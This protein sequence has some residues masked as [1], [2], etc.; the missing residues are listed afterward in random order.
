MALITTPT[1][2][3]YLFTALRLHINDNTEPYTF[4]DD[5]LRT[6]LVYAVKALQPRWNYKYLVDADNNT[7]RNPNVT[8]LFP[9][10]P[11]VEYGDERP[12]V[13]QAAIDMLSAQI[14]SSSQSAVSWKDD[15]VSFSNISGNKM[16]E[17]AL[18]R[19]IAEL[20]SLVPLPS[21]RLAST[22][23]QSLKGFS[24]EVGNDYEG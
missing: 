6:R 9:D 12:I 7:S 15:E 11:T 21:M 18:I 20:Q 22:R 10:P 23:K 17:D 19:D 1:N 5:E 8:Y 13:L 14:K 3:D 4:S 24:W 16:L 2:L